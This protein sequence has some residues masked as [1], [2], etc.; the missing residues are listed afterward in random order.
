MYALLLSGVDWVDEYR[1]TGVQGEVT[2]LIVSPHEF[3]TKEFR[4]E[5]FRYV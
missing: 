3:M 1:D 2:F 5:K 4:K